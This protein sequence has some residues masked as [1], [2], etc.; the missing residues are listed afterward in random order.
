MYEKIA[1]FYDRLGW[2]Q[3]PLKLWDQMENYFKQ[4]NF[5][6]SNHLDIACGTGVLSIKAVTEGLL[7]EGL[8]FSIDMLEFARENAKSKNVDINFYHEDMRNFNLNK[9]Y[10]LITCT[11]DAINHLLTIDE[12]KQTFTQ[13][14]NHLNNNGMF[15]FDC[16]TQKALKERWN[17]IQINK[18]S[19][20]NYMIQKAIHYEDKGISTASF[21]VFFKEENGLFDSFEDTFTEIAFSSTEVINL[22][23]EVG[24]EEISITDT[25]FNRID[26]PDEEYRNVYICK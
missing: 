26:H 19:K 11:Y 8:D 9:K 18:D 24:F 16:N 14:K 17:S 10:D 6:P 21:T 20:G 13:V 1:K 3:F 25:N 15:I 23:R 4:E 7:S 5:H 2:S 22:L 12:W